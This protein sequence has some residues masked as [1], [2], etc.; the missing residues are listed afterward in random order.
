MTSQALSAQNFDV[1]IGTYT[2]NSPSKGIYHASFDA[3]SGTLS[4]PELAA[5]T[6]D[7]SFLAFSPDGRFVYATAGGNPGKI[8]AF[9]IQKD[10]KLRF[11]GES[12]SGGNGPCH[13]IMTSDG[14][15][16]LTANYGS[17][18]V[19]LIP[20]GADGIPAHEP[21]CIIQHEGRGTDPRRQAGPHAHSINPS[22]DGKHIYAADLGLDKILIYNLDSASVKLKPAVPPEAVLKDASGPRH[23]TFNPDG[24]TAY[25]INE[26]DSTVTVLSRNPSTGALTI[27]QNISTCPPDFKG[28]TWC[29]E[30]RLHPNGKFLYAS[31]RGHDSLAVFTVNKDGTLTS[32]GFQSEHI[33]TP[34][35][36]NIDPTGRYCLVANQASDNL[37]L[38]KIDQNSGLL[39]FTGRIITAGEPVY[40]G[41]LPM[42][43]P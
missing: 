19:A 32:P 1:Y 37:A 4:E 25:V 23:M 28:T 14:R 2:K 7:P 11:I 6:P 3:D 21:S 24:K 40:V 42:K 22:P 29:A 16:L 13:L 12:L 38:F 33:K 15:N 31:N 20:V 26:L 10:K 35:H 34:R 41:F 27:V 8:R 30:V 9:E 5:E 43:N 18:S 39:E 36:F 17:G